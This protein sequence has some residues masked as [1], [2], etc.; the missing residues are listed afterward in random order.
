MAH[1]LKW[2][3]SPSARS[4]RWKRTIREQRKRVAQKLRETPSL[5]PL[6]S[7]RAWIDGAWGDAVTAAPSET[8]LDA[9]RDTCPFSFD[10]HALKEGWF[11]A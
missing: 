10:D 3:F 11:P 8:G 4:R 9:M 1:L 7:D 2:R 6:L 5:A